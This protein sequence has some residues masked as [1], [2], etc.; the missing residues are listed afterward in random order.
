MKRAEESFIVIAAFTKG[1][2]IAVFCGSD[3]IH[4]EIRPNRTHLSPKMVTK[5]FSENLINTAAR[6]DAETIL[7]SLPSRTQLAWRSNRRR[8]NSITRAIEKVG[9]QVQYVSRQPKR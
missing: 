6:F 2:G 7:I 4:F 8:F 3:L 5:R 9:L 1:T